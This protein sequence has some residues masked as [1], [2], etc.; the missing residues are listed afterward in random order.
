MSRN[1]PAILLNPNKFDY[2]LNELEIG[3]LRDARQALI[4][5]NYNLVLNSLWKAVNNN[6]KRRIEKYGINEFL[7]NLDNSEKNIY[8]KNS[9][10]ISQKFSLLN[11]LV[12][13]KN[14][15]K[16]KIISERTYLVLNF[17]YWLSKNNS[18]EKIT[19]LDITSVSSLLEQNL[20]K[21]QIDFKDVNYQEKQPTHKSNSNQINNHA[22]IEN[23][24][25]RRKD[26]YSSTQNS[27]KKIRKEELLLIQSNHQRKR[28]KD[29]IE[30]EEFQSFLLRRKDDP[31][32]KHQMHRRRKDDFLHSP[33]TKPQRR[34]DDIE[35]NPTLQVPRKRRKDD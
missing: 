7:D 16:L 13:I 28:R 3:H 31:I 17:F 34:K 18:N 22:I 21:V 12:I 9:Y 32:N 20:F 33:N 2:S 29:D 11:N 8:F 6:L 15:F 23:N 24:L 19:F 14:S 5:K 26:D 10:S 4:K 30:K 35:N 1:L 27:S 25:K